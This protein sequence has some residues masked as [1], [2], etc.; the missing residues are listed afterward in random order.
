MIPIHQRWMIRR[1]LP[2]VL[3]IESASHRFPWSER[4]IER[5]LR[6]RNC[7]GR[8]A[9]IPHGHASPHDLERCCAI[10]FALFLLGARTHIRLL[11]LA[12]DPILRRLGVGTALVDHLKAKLDPAYFPGRQLVV[13]A[14]E[15]EL[16]GLLFLRSQGF[17]ATEVVR[18]HFSDSGE[19][20]VVMRF[21]AP[22]QESWLLK[23]EF[24]RDC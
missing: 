19:D 18:N 8:V 24:S 4:D 7:I 6:Q 15:T 9:L 20:A 2:E 23:E 22:E 1:D 16:D 11:N 14:R 10:G 3:A 17:Q 12:V 5:R 13:W 21:T